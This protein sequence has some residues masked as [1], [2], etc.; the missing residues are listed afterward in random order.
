M[1]RDLPDF[2][3]TG[4]Y[5]AEVLDAL[6][7]A[8]ARYLPEHT[9]TGD[10]DPLNRILALQALL[11]H[12]TNVTI[13]HVALEV[14]WATA[15]L[16]S[17]F[18]PWAR[19]LSYPLAGPTP[20][21]AEVL[22]EL[23]GR[24]TGTA[25]VW[26]AGSRAATRS[27]PGAAP[28]LFELLDGPISVTDTGTWLTRQDDGGVLTTP[29]WPLIDPWGGA[30]E[31]GD[32][33]YF[34]HAT[35]MFTAIGIN[36]LNVGQERLH[37]SWEYRDDRR[38]TL[39]DLVTDLG[40]TIRLRVDELLGTDVQGGIRAD[41][42]PVRV[43]CLV[44]GAEETVA[45]VYSGGQHTITTTGTLGQG[46]VST[47]RGDYRLTAE[48][49]PLPGF[50][51]GT[52]SGDLGFYR[53]NQAV[54]WAH[55]DGDNRRWAKATVDGVEAFWVRAR[56]VFRE[57]VSTPNQLRLA[58]PA[59]VAAT[60]WIVRGTFR[61]GETVTERLG[62]SPLGPD[63]GT[64][65]LSRSPIMRVVGVTVA[66]EAWTI[67]DSFLSASPVDRV[68]RVRE[69]FD[70]TTSVAFGDGQRGAVP[71]TPGD[72]VASYLV[73][74]AESGN[75]GPSEIA[76]DR[77][78]NSRLRAIRNP[79][80]AAGW[81]PAEGSTPADLELLRERLPEFLAAGD[82]AV[83]PDDYETL[84]EA[85][86]TED[87]LQLA[88]RVVAIEEGQGPKTVECVI[89]GRGGAVPTADELAELDTFYN[90]APIGL[91]REGGKAPGNTR[92][93]PTAYTP[94]VVNVTATL[95]V[96]RGY[97]AGATAAGRAALNGALQ[98]TARRLV[99]DGQGRL[100]EGTA[101]QW[102]LGGSV[103]LITLSARLAINVPGFVDVAFA[104][105]SGA[106]ALGARELPYPGT[107]TLSIVEVVA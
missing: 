106:V 84:G 61:Q 35:A 88:A 2:D 20:A 56:I 41:D 76:V 105:P 25:V 11:A 51:D 103:D 4:L 55:P 74:G 15:R 85:Y 49:L 91:E 107:I 26:A 62:S 58:L 90:G 99:P 13:D 59:E 104:V 53:A 67:V 46:V 17:S 52:R 97:G 81:L 27:A 22:G 42:L 40:G 70:G 69:E 43:R 60:A 6:R 78:G 24:V 33:L 89:V 12:R 66:G 71:S 30:P 50:V 18:V 3:W 100:V 79:T 77:S 48:W 16:R 93:V 63:Q 86:R 9:E 82:R 80:A 57:N 73:G 65:T 28:I 45:V 8:K 83:T 54:S 94:R 44:T 39:P 29:A 47:N 37:Y 38:E 98:P 102:R 32:G 64:I 101:F 1:A 10:A 68:V 95:T 5:Y 75:V 7:R 96:L 31:E 72:I 36:V 23:G 21:L 34:G 87:G 19:L 92:G 14:L